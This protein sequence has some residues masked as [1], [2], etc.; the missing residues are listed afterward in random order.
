M[1]RLT[2]REKQG[3]QTVRETRLPAPPDDIDA[4][5]AAFF[6]DFDGTLAEIVDDP[7]T[8]RVDDGVL[9]V[10]ATLQDLCGGALAI[11]SGREIADLDRRLS[12]LRMAAAGVH[13][14]EWRMP[15]GLISRAKTDDG[16]LADVHGEAGRIASR[17]AG[18]VLE[19]KSG[20]LSLHY[21]MCPDMA[22]V[23]LA[24]AHDIRQRFPSIHVVEG[25]MVV[26]FK[27]SARTK[28]DA[29]A[30]F[31]A[32]PPFAG[33]LPVFAGD[34]TTDEAG[35]SQIDAWNGI[36]IKIGSGATRA[37]YR[38]MHP[39][40]LHDWLAGLAKGACEPC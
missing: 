5:R 40:A 13:G 28:G 35:F 6:L 19:V 20:S 39:A 9:S 11:V 16:A 4:T 14:L 31:M 18:M 8:A 21:R 27:A 36:S 33:R 32:R 22:P 34:D 26:E 7:A 25:K 1:T 30:S 24:F 12:P 17:H 38:L 37:R 23:S 29:L 10:L 3:K 15:D 2:I